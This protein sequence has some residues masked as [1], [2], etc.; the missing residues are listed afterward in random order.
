MRVHFKSGAIM[1]KLY[2]PE[3]RS[4]DN[5]ML[6]PDGKE[7]ILFILAQICSERVFTNPLN[8]WVV[9]RN[10]LQPPI[11]RYRNVRLDVVGLVTN[12]HLQ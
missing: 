9:G 1:L 3:V 11:L 4:S 5:K 6:N 2:P 10:T 12:C 8:A 7:Y